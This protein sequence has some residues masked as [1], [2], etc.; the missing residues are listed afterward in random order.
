[1]VA[2]SKP[3]QF[4]VGH[5]SEMFYSHFRPS[6]AQNGEPLPIF[7][8]KRLYL[9]E[10]L[11]LYPVILLTCCQLTKLIAKCSF[12]IASFTFLFFCCPCSTFFEMHCCHQSL[13]ELIFSMKWKN[14]SVSTSD[15]LFIGNEIW[16]YEILQII[17]FYFYLDQCTTVNFH[18]MR[19]ISLVSFTFHSHCCTCC[20]A[21]LHG[22]EEDK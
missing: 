21:T 10:M 5:F 1:M 6:L 18:N 15:T 9:S 20:S 7:T 14:V 22:E 17:V 12:W 13:N 3:L 19:E 8:S 2:S 16:F 4:Y 11:P